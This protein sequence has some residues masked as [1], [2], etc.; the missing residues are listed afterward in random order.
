M[1]HTGSE[2]PPEDPREEPLPDGVQEEEQRKGLAWRKRLIFGLIVVVCLSVVGR[3]QFAKRAAAAEAEQE[4]RL[5]ENPG[6]ATGLVPGQ[7]EGEPTGQEAGA[8]MVSTQTSTVALGVV[9]ATYSNPGTSRL[10]PSV[11]S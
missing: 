5:A 10:H 7:I 8:E 6:M 9:E 11:V 1:E 3:V 4:R 2:K